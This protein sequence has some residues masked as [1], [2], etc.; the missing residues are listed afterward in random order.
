LWYRQV[1]TE[2]TYDDACALARALD[3]VGERWTLLVVRELL[4]GPKRFASL[5][6]GL[7]AIS[8]N[9][10]ARRIREMEQAGL[11]ERIVLDP[12]ANIPAY[13]LTTRGLQLRPVLIALTRWGALEAPSP[14]AGLS[15]AALLLGLSALYEPS[16]AA[17]TET[18][19]VTIGRETF[20][21]IASPQAIDVKPGDGSGGDGFRIAGPVPAVR[22]VLG[23]GGDAAPYEARG[24]L[25]ISGDRASLARLSRCFAAQPQ[26]GLASRPA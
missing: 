17:G 14:D 25:T 2:R 6:A 16:R 10:L 20:T 8:Q 22:A 23:Q 7:P 3:V 21:L 13:R 5:R 18:G 4:L 1:V 15:P 12:P 9:V 11:V 26:P 19:V 24:E